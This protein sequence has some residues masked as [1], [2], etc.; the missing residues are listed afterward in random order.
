MMTREKVQ[1][2]RHH[3]LPAELVEELRAGIDAFN[4]RN[5]RSLRTSP[6]KKFAADPTPLR[7]LP[8][9]V[10]A[11]ALLPR[12]Q[13]K[14]IQKAGIQHNGNFYRHPRLNRHAGKT[15]EIGF[16]DKDLSFVHVF[17]DGKHLCKA[18]AKPSRAMAGGLKASRLRQIETFNRIE[19]GSEKLRLLSA[20]LS[21]EDYDLDVRRRERQ[22]RRPKSGGRARSITT[23]QARP[24]RRAAHLE[25]ETWKSD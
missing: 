10:L 1:P 13:N 15:V 3:L 5:H 16:T 7:T 4:G 24:G 2:I 20:G 11:L 22:N 9:R 18:V 17:L 21:A 8:E 23:N 12:R 6:V 25:D 19:L 14:V